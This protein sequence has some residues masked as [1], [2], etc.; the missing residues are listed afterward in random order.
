MHLLAAAT[1]KRTFSHLVRYLGGP[2]LIVLGLVDNSFIPL[3]GSMDAATIVLAAAHSEPWWY[4]AIMALI[5]SLIGGYLTYRIGL[6]GGQETLDKKLPKKRAEQA[7]RIFQ[8][9]GFWSVAVTAICPPPVPIVPTL[10]VAGALKYPPVKFLTALALG[11]AAR[12]TLLAYLG[13]RYG[14]HI[15]GWLSRYHQPLL[16][17]LIALAVVGTLVAL[18]YWWRQRTHKGD[19]SGQIHKAA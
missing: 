3:P 15:V 10:I 13:H 12:Y 14:R 9:Y 6:K 2:G 1:V 19:A 8:R 7:N 11:R 17:A 16:Y 5:G 4:Y 18:Y